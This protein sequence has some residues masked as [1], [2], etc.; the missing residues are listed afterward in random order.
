MLDHLIQLEEENDASKNEPSYH[1][2][3]SVSTAD[4]V[5]GVEG[6]VVSAGS[7]GV[8]GTARSAVSRT[9]RAASSA[10]IQVVGTTTSCTSDTIISAACAVCWTSR[11]VSCGI[12]PVRGGAVRASSIIWKVASSATR[13]VASLVTRSVGG[14][15]VQVGIAYLASS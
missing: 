1:E 3:G 6:Q 7:A 11:A 10:A 12:Q 13:N 5:F 9:S 2:S 15:Q 8:A 4:S 14:V